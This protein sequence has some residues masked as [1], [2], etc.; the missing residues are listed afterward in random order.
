MTDSR[1]RSRRHPAVVALAVI[2]FAESALLTAAAIYLLVELVVATPASLPSAIALLILAALA[3]VWLAVIA[4]NSL[5]GAS[6]VAAATIVWQ[7]L[8]VAVAIGCFQGAFAQP[9]VGWLLLIP[10]VVAGVLVFS[11]P[12]R[13]ATRRAPAA[14]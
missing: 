9:A 8:Q 10:A 1:A 11:R 12:V 6:W 7:V 2:L 5:R 3:A 4:I 14:S 13:E